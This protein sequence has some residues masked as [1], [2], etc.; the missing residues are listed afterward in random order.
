M[1]RFLNWFNKFQLKRRIFLVCMV[2]Y[3]VT[4][5]ISTLL[6]LYYK[7][8][9]TFGLI[10]FLIGTLAFLFQY[11]YVEITDHKEYERKLFNKD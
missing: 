4:F 9:T 5:V 10:L 3:V 11:L 6:Q 7:E 1:K 8:N 2:F